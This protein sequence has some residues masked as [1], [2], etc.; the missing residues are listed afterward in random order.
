M[1]NLF[2]LTLFCL[3]FLSCQEDEQQLLN[4]VKARTLSGATAGSNQSY[5]LDV[6]EDG[7]TDFLFTTTLNEVNDLIEEHFKV[8]PARANAIFDVGST[9]GNL[10]EGTTIGPGNPFDKNVNALVIKRFGNPAISWTGPWLNITNGIIGFRLQHLEK[11]YYGWVRVGFN[12][13][14]ETLTITEVA[15]NTRPDSPVRAGRLD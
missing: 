1:R 8:Y 6:N 5:G 14:N 2:I 9:A 7:E 15:Y 10:E 13:Q 12:Q 4:P 11:N 3:T